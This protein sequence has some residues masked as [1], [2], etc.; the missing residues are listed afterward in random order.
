M[1]A[2]TSGSKARPAAVSPPMRFVRSNSAEPSAASS[3]WMSG[4]G[5]VA[6]F[7]RPVGPA[8]GF[9]QGR[10]S[11]RQRCQQFHRANFAQPPFRTTECAG[12]EL[13]ALRKRTQAASL[14]PGALVIHF[15]VFVRA[16][17]L[18][19]LDFIG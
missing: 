7:N 19:T 14:T 17:V 18:D 12:L 5:A 1:M 16:K 9:P 11:V 13:F 2:S 6:G 10:D 8:G 15:R 3:C 4:S